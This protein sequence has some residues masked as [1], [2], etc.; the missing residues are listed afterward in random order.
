MECETVIHIGRSVGA[1]G[2]AHDEASA[3]STTICHCVTK[4]A[5]NCGDAE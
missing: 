1:Q 3:C 2:I 5:L 4:G